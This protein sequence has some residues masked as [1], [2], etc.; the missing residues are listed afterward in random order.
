MIDRGTNGFTLGHVW[1]IT[2]TPGQGRST[3]AIQWALQVATHHGLRTDLFSLKEPEHLLAVR[4]LGSA[5]KIP[6]PHL[7]ENDTTA[8]DEPKLRPAREVL[9]E[10]PMQIAGPHRTSVLTFESPSADTPQA[11]VVDDA[12]LA[13]GALPERLAGFAA[14]G[15]LVIVTLPKHQ[16][17]GPDG[18]NPVWA[19]VADYI[20]EID[21]PDLLDAHSLRPG[22]A[23]LHLLRNRWGPQVTATVAFQGHYARFVEMMPA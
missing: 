18:I 16:V 22:E 19:H 5:G 13:A 14:Q 21:R 20:V 15:V 3:L 12:H 11:L 1:I 23:D 4:L 9:A 7:W 10:A 2:G 8:D 6:V 17:I